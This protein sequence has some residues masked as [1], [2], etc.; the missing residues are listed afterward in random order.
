MDKI[1]LIF[2]ILN[3]LI[4]VMCRSCCADLKVIVEFVIKKIY[5]YFFCYTNR[6]IN[7]LTKKK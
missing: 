6:Y 1:I 3:L 4:L 7:V 5:R 2:F